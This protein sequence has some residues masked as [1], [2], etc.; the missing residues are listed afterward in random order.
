MGPLSQ[1]LCLICT[2]MHG[3][4]YA[5]MRISIKHTFFTK[6]INYHVLSIYRDNNDLNIE[7]IIP[8]LMNNM[9]VII[10]KKFLLKTSEWQRTSSPIPVQF[11]S[12]LC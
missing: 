9:F 8:I 11:R 7:N 4:T 2:A 10:H 6:D 1:N 12:N 5:S 3:S